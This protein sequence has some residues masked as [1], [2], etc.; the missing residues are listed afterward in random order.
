[1]FNRTGY[2]SRSDKEYVIMY[3][4]YVNEYNVT[5]YTATGKGYKAIVCNSH[6]YTALSVI[7]RYA[8]YV[9]R[10]QAYT[11]RHDV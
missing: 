7:Y 4:H 5:L 2:H 6:I 9:N 10:K 1:M 3:C 8:Y 11:Q